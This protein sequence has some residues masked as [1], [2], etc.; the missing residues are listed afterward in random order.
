MN[1]ITNLIVENTK[2]SKEELTGKSQKIEINNLRYFAY[3]YMKTV[4]GMSLREIAKQFNRNH[5]SVFNGLKKFSKLM[6]EDK[7]YKEVINSLI[8]KL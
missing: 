1:K 6:Q 8:I 3:H 5:P 4:K 7:E 2:Y